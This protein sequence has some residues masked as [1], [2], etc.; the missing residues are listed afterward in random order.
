MSEITRREFGQTMVGGMGASVL[1]EHAGAVRQSEQPGRPNILFI[2]SD[3]HSGRMLGSAGHALVRTP[4]LDRLASM[5]V[6]FKNAYSGNPVCVPARASM[7]T[8]RFAS[9]V[10]SYCNSTPF[11]GRAPTWGNLLRQSGYFCWATGKLDLKEGR[12]YGFEESG[13]SHGHSSSPDITSLFRRPVCYRV[14]E[15]R[16]IDGSFQERADHDEETLNATLTFLEN[17]ARRLG[18]PWVAY[19]GLQKPHPPFVAHARYRHLYPEYNIPMPNLPPGYLE[20]LH[21]PLQI[22]R[23]FKMISTPIP[24]ERVRRARAAYYGMVTELDD[25]IGGFLDRL[26]QDGLLENTLIVYTSDHGEM[27]GEN[28]LWLKNVLLEGAARVPIILV[29]AGLPQGKVVDTPVAHVDLVATLLDVA[30]VPLPRGLR[31]SSLLPLVQGRAST[32]PG[33]AFSESH[34]EGNCTGSFLVRKGDWKYVHYTWYGNLLFNLKED[35]WE[36]NNLSGKPEF[37]AAEK[38]LHTTLTSLVDP[39]AVTNQA[40]KEQDRILQQIIRNMG[41]DQF[42]KE[43]TGRLGAGQATVLTRRYYEKQ[44]AGG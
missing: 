27:L 14:D 36:L 10:G 16:S 31:G 6:L 4:N 5:G 15:R 18:K 9:D 43:L 8:G 41:A 21:L 25:N 32:H 34:S 12:D 44:V 19:V 7:M 11:D 1:G 22:L 30:G 17:E 29:G 24:E 38:E 26:R 39:E 35:P 37:A 3:Q 20:T 33:Y 23:S 28:G 2:C 13:T 42:L 40:F